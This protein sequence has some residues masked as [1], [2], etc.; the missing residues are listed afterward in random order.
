MVRRGDDRFV[1]SDD[2]LGRR[3]QR[4]VDDGRLRGVLTD[5]SEADTK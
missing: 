5:C 2:S 3:T 1:R 4:I